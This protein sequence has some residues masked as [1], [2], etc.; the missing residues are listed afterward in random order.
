MS[1]SGSDILDLA[2]QPLLE[3]G[4]VPGAGKLATIESKTL[5]QGV[6]FE[7]AVDGEGDNAACLRAVGFA[8]ERED[9]TEEVSTT[10]LLLCKRVI[11]IGY[12]RSFSLGIEDAVSKE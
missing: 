12:Y 1:A 11:L 2:F 10:D 8:E 9:M 3:G 7:D 4:S 6:S 5:L